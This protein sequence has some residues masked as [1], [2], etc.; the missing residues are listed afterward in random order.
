LKVAVHQPQYFPY[1]G[2]FHKLSLVDA[3][4][5]MDDVQYDKR[6]TNRNRI[7]DTHGIIWLTV[8]INRKQKFSPNREVEV[9]NDLHWAPD[10]LKKILVS[11]SNARHFHGYR[12][13]LEELY[14]RRWSRL[15]DLDVQTLKLSMKWLGIEVPIVMESSL[16]VETSG[17]QRIAEVCKALGADTYVSGVGGHAYLDE[18]LLRAS[19]INLEYQNYTPAAYPQRLAKQFVPNLSIIDMLANVGPASAMYVARAKGAEVPRE[20]ESLVT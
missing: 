20:A 14:R 19:G 10:H 8:P 5:L 16:G 13:E 1:P 11:Y 4:V 18:K 9:N 7:L 3:F 12:N 2:F 6:Y 17:T 15:L